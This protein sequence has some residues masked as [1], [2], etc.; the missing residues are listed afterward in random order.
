MNDSDYSD[1]GR[2]T[3]RKAEPSENQQ[4]RQFEGLTYFPQNPNPSV[5][6][7]QPNIQ[8]SQLSG[9]TS[10]IDPDTGV[11]ASVVPLQDPE[12]SDFTNPDPQ[13][14]WSDTH[15]PSLSLSENQPSQTPVQTRGSLQPSSAFIP[16]YYPEGTTRF[17][18]LPSLNAH[19]ANFGSSPYHIPV[20]RSRT[21]VSC[22]SI[23]SSIQR[24][25]AYNDMEMIGRGPD[26]PE[27]DISSRID[28]RAMH[29]NTSISPMI[30]NFL[31]SWVDNIFSQSHNSVGAPSNDDINA[32]A[33]LARVSRDD[34]VQSLSSSERLNNILLARRHGH[35]IQ[36]TYG[37]QNMQTRLSTTQMDGG[38]LAYNGPHAKLISDYV[39]K[40]R[41]KCDHGDGRRISVTGVLECT[42][43]CGYR[44][45][46]LSDWKRHEENRQ[47]QNIYVCR[48][49][50]RG[51]SK[52]KP[53][54]SHRVDKLEKHLRSTHKKAAAT[55]L[56][57]DTIT[58]GSKVA[59]QADFERE[60]KEPGCP[61]SFNS[62]DD[63]L[64]H[65][66]RDHF[67]GTPGSQSS[68]Y[69]AENDVTFDDEEEMSDA[70]RDINP[71]PDW[72]LQC[73]SGMPG[74]STQYYDYG[75]GYQ[76]TE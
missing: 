49:C 36:T 59:Y 51:P 27:Q 16:P 5:P 28:A 55:R 39:K 4:R 71:H 58:G 50:Q 76:Q 18:L 20:D 70:P 8:T 32:L 31:E 64:S 47:P 12:Y 11:G 22:A 54:I 75:A 30:A 15:F 35:N 56:E 61:H 60:C 1:D 25:H 7:F 21:D 24:S 46:R 74:P 68:P 40:A 10:G 65:Y 53:F 72:D 23:P 73:V 52:K 67:Q 33:Y 44:T 57:I 29:G 3:K 2:S 19:S 43:G 34:V 17:E 37:S 38:N 69:T 48:E 63:R 9:Q 14:V 42:A 66:Q 41:N 62:W 6:S 26:F 13:R 45:N